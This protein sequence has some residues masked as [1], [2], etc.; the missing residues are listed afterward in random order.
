MEERERLVGARAEAAAAGMY[1]CAPAI[2][3][4]TRS[5]SNGSDSARDRTRNHEQRERER[6]DLASVLIFS[7]LLPL[8]LSSLLHPHQSTENP[9]VYVSVGMSLTHTQRDIQNVKAARK[10]AAVILSV[11]R[12][13]T[14]AA[15]TMFSRTEQPHAADPQQRRHSR[16]RQ[17]LLSLNPQSSHPPPQHGWTDRCQGKA[18]V[19]AEEA[20]TNHLAD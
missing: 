10:S 8:S 7:L 20:S 11:G 3:S 17:L 6:E 9:C 19:C 14:R 4:H 13:S 2:L 18:A 1:A 5:S 16:Q 12:G 15:A